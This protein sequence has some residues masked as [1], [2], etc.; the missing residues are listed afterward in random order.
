M[1]V[2][3]ERECVAL[4]ADYEVYHDRHVVILL[5]ENISFECMIQTNFCSL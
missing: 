1:F 3:S 5:G 4:E 2:M